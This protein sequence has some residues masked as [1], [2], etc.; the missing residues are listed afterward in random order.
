M[1]KISPAQDLGSFTKETVR[2]TG[3]WEDYYGTRRFRGLI[4]APVEIRI[5]SLCRNDLPAKNAGLWAYAKSGKFYQPD[6]EVD[7]LLQP[8]FEGTRFQPIL[9]CGSAINADAQLG[10]ASARRFSVQEDFEFN[11]GALV[12][13]AWDSKRRPAIKLLAFAY[14]DLK[15]LRNGIWA[16]KP[17]FRDA[18]PEPWRLPLSKTRKGWIGL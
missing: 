7:L 1:A 15:K 6:F 8:T 4:Q 13:W 14:T 2:L 17:R 12:D 3:A 16:V 5:V 18:L 9:R 11:T 10:R